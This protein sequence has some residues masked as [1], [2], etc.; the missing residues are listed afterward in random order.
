MTSVNE[1]RELFL[2]FFEDQGHV[3]K[4]SAPL[5]PQ[6]DPSLLF[7]NAGMVPF[8]NIFTGNEAPISPRVASAQ[9][10]LRAGGKHNDLDNVGYTARHHTFFEM[11][12]NFS[13]GDYFKEKAIKLAWSFVTEKLHLDP[14]RLL[15]T[16]YH[17]DDVAADL[18]RRISGLPESRIIRIET[19]DNFWSMGATGP[20]GPSSEIF[21]DHGEGVSGGPPGSADED[22]DR[23][24]E[25]WNLVF[26]QYDQSAS[27]ERVPLPEPSIDTGMGLERVSAVLQGVHNN[28]EID[29]FETLIAAEQD[30]Y[31]RTAS[32]ADLPSFRII[33]DHLRASAF[34][35]ADGVMPSN[36][37]RG[38][39]LRRIMRRAMRHAHGLGAKEPSMHRLVD[40]LVAE[41]GTQYPELAR[42]AAMIR[43]NLEQEEGRFQRT[44]GRG[45][46]LLDEET[47]GMGSGDCLDGATAF[48]LY[49]TYGFPLDLTEDILRARGISVDA[50][51]FQEAMGQQRAESRGAWSGSGDA[52]L[53]K[54]WADVRS[55]SGATRFSGHE[56][57]QGKGELKAIV[58]EAQSV[59][60]IS[61]GVAA[62]IFDTTPFYAESGGQSG[63]RGLVCFRGGA[64]FI[65]HDTTKIMDMHVHHGELL[66]G[67]IQTGEHAELEI[68][69][70]R[71]QRLMA[72]H[73]A[74]HLLH[75]ALRRTLGEHVTQKGSL[76][77]ADHLR[78]DFSHGAPVT[79]EEIRAIEEEVNA[80]ILG[81][82][83]TACHVSSPD[84]AIEAGALA[85][86][87]ENYGDAVRVLSI[88]ESLET[89]N[90][91]YSVELCGGTHVERTGDIGAFVVMSESGV[92]AGVRRLVAATGK[93]AIDF[94][95][96][97]AD[98]ASQAADRLRV[99]LKELPGRVDS[100]IEERRSLENALGDARRRLALSGGSTTTDQASEEIGGTRLFARVVE[101]VGGKDLRALVDDAK[102][103][104]ESGIVA[105]VGVTDGKAALAVGVTEDL[106]GTLSAVDLV[107]TA[108][109]A[110]GGKGGGGRADMAQAGGPNGER[111]DDALDALRAALR[112]RA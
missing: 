100:L 112:D 20:C 57:W 16:I 50:R 71:R 108:S 39:V 56:S 44:L 23:F 25:I 30:V 68:D 18:W 13:F 66:Q 65:V 76:V 55:A 81:N 92:A 10:C 110:I 53:D 36:E 87:G 2:S 33:A 15:V 52:G 98:I 11:L 83:V 95:R 8:K 94:L 28:Y 1:I 74:T 14:K 29:L 48:M 22:G 9:K 111:A 49:D 26:M 73:S 43:S 31:G 89:D 47:S 34:L 67:E 97:R 82:A 105:F 85:L 58:Q 75:A 96:G 51:G 61:A 5:V 99:P 84:E 3:R 46:A 78:F 19:S 32:E 37:G 103:Q 41:M 91:P 54:T 80:V 38:Y 107:R 90:T 7:V 93:D 104:I 88:G 35:M 79:P 40:P 77:E 62:L 21:Y 17:D 6:N 86:F 60:R 63:D 70:N 4:D 45:L 69:R 12:G 106:T 64:E 109:K 42:G 59:E 102:A 101:G 27:G 24:V 72:N